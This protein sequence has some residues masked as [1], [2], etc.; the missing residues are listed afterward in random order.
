MFP[1]LNVLVIVGALF[2]P[3]CAVGPVYQSPVSAEVSPEPGLCD[4]IA[5]Q[6]RR[7]YQSDALD[8]L[9]RS[10]VK[11]SPSVAQA[12]AALREAGENLNAGRGTSRY[13]SVD[14]SLAAARRKTSPSS[15]GISSGK[16]NVFSLYNASVNVTYAFD[17]FG[18]GRREIEGLT[19]AV[20]YQRFQLEAALLSL[21]ANIATAA[22]KEASLSA[23]LKAENDVVAL[24]RQQL[25]LLE[26][27]Q[28]LGSVTRAG[29]LAQ[30]SLME[31]ARAQ[32]PVLEKELALT[33][34]SLA[35][36]SGQ[37]PSAE[38]KIPAFDLDMIQLPPDLPQSVSSEIVEQ[39]P[40]VRAAEAL[41]RSA[42]AQV[43]AATANLYPQFTL[44]GS[45]GP[46]AL[47]IGDLFDVH[48][49]VWN[50]G[51]GVLQPLFNGGALRAKQRAAAAVYE[52]SA[53]HF[54]ETVLLAYQNIADALRSLESDA[55]AIHAQEVSLATAREALT[56]TQGQFKAGAVNIMLLLDAEQRYRQV[57]IGLIQA[58]A[59]YGADIAA[60]VQALGGSW[61]NKEGAE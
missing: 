43:G 49:I 44:N 35:V 17:I 33:R 22:F 40:D 42:S 6:W 12:Q 16:G 24:M 38:K 3:G 56:L 41:L 14:A 4:G 28:A 19:S 11:E 51:A 60:L 27:Q 61:H 25:E 26:K 59:A 2:V 50:A 23:Q 13:P 30:R 29:V 5:D 10:A 34:H 21:S 32:I 48:N 58:R 7:V 36:L 45:Y 15:A 46:Q 54:R 18:S 37:M 31:Q 52:Q 8:R 20:D 57:S 53:A 1:L 55:L 9:I 47:R 39:R